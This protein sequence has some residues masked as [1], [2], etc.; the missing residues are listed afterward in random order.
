MR[1]DVRGKSLNGI[2]QIIAAAA[3]F[4]GLRGRPYHVP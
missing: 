4:R 2:G 1:H 3:Q